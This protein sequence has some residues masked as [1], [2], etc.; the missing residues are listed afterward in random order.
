LLSTN[1]TTHNIDL[2]TPSQLVLGAQDYDLDLSGISVEMT[3]GLGWHAL[4]WTLTSSKVTPAIVGGSATNALY[5][6]IPPTLE[7]TPGIIPFN[8]LPFA[9]SSQG[10]GR[11]P[12]EWMGLHVYHSDQ[13]PAAHLAHRGNYVDSRGGKP[14]DRFKG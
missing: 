8:D 7:L 11:D 6:I 1:S 14:Y 5:Q 4:P 12:L 3:Q 2:S 10:F 9:D 13:Q